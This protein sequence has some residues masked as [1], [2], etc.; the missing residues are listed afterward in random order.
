MCMNIHTYFLFC[1]YVYMYSED[2][3]TAY[4]TTFCIQDLTPNP[5]PARTHSPLPL[6]WINILSDSW[7]SFSPEVEA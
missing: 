6:F 7:K 5:P 4:I 1:L 3:Q 2:L